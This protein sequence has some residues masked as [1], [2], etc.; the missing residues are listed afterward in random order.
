[1]QAKVQKSNE[2]D[3]IEKVGNR[4]AIKKNVYGNNKQEENGSYYKCLKCGRRHVE[5]QCFTFGKI[6]NNCGRIGHFS[7][8]CNLDSAKINYNNNGQ[9]CRSTNRFNQ[10]Y[11]VTNGEQDEP[12]LFVDCI[13]L[14][15]VSYVKKS[16]CWEEKVI[17]EDECIAFKLDTGAQCNL[18]SIMWV[19]KLGKGLDLEKS[20]QKL[21]LTVIMQLR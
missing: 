10:V 19:K 12:D 14:D 20:D 7:V 2:V 9:S 3:A 4:G 5:G 17:I 18:L 1:M 13:E 16:K 6:C 15:N 11:E 21:L 8:G